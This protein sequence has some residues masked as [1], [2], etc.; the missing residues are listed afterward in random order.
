MTLTEVR[1]VLREEHKVAVEANGGVERTP[2]QKFQ[3]FEQVLIGL[4]EEGHITGAQFNKW[5]NIY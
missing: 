5:I 1:K 2:L 4:L 3:V